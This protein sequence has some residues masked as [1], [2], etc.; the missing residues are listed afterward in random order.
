MSESGKSDNINNSLKKRYTV[1]LLIGIAAL[2]CYLNGSALDWGARGAVWTPDTIEG[3]RTAG[4]NENMFKLWKHKY[5][6]GQFLISYPFYKSKIDYWKENPITYMKDGKVYKSVIDTGRQVELS[7]IT[8][9]LCY[10]MSIAIVFAVFFT[11]R[12]LFEDDIAALLSCLCL[13]LS[14]YF[15]FFS[16]SGC[17]D[18]PAMFWFALATCFGVYAAYNRKIY[19]YLPA[20]FCSAWSVCTKEGV[21]P[22]QVGLFLGLAVLQVYA[23]YSSGKPFKQAMKSLL[24]WKILSAIVIA[25]IVFMTLENF[26]TGMEEWNYRSQFWEDVVSD[27][28][29]SRISAM[30][31]LTSVGS[32]FYQGWGW[33]FVVLM[34]LSLPYVAYKYKWQFVFIAAPSILFA[35]AV[36][37]V[38]NQTR[39]RFW[40]CS[41]IGI[42]LMMGKALADWYRVKKIP[43]SIRIVAPLFVLV[44]SLLCCIFFN[45]EMNNDSRIRVSNWMKKN[46]KPG[47]IVGF[48]MYDQ[49][50]PRLQELGF[51]VID[52]FSSKGIQTKKGLIKVS[53]DY[54][55]GSTIFPMSSRN[56]IEY[57]KKVFNDQTEYKKQAV[58]GAIYFRNEDSLMWKLCLR[59]F[60]LQH[61]ISPDVRIYKKAGN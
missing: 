55:I 61:R 10:I 6:R 38:I 25:V 27:F 42:A 54:F 34:I 8:R 57:F 58:M 1:L 13:T 24:S 53:P 39:P 47:A 46:A 41:Y 35:I 28:S 22:F 16:K 21:A 30:T 9:R 52:D 7:M 59:F 37:F 17:V 51:R 14:C 43:F 26:W 29:K 12:K 18:I 19:W 23:V 56:D 4:H 36:I 32:G 20:G 49:Y 44:P 60:H 33:P 15:V 31:L 50:G 40:F 5:P 11:S 48:P 45:I 3:L 2:A